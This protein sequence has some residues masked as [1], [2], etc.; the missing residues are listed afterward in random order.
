MNF[1]AL[2]VETA[3]A[4][5]DSICQIGL[6]FFEAGELVRVETRLVD[7]E[8]FF[9][10]FNVSIHGIDED[11]VAGQSNF[12]GHYPWLVNAVAGRIVVTHTAFDVS[13]VRQ[14]C[15]RYGLTVPQVQW[16][17]SARVVRRVW[18]FCAQAGYGLAPLCERFG[19]G[20]KH[21]DAGEDAAA[22][23][24][25]LVRAMGDAGLNEMSLRACLSRP[26]T[27]PLVERLSELSPNPQGEYFGQT[28]VFTGVLAL[29]R[30]DAAKTAADH[31]FLVADGVNKHTDIL[32]VGNQDV[33]KLAGHEKSAKQRKAEQMQIKGKSI[34]I[35]REVDFIDLL[36][37]AAI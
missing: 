26:I 23:G 35:L 32:V 5:F 1:V 15:D 7:P 11:A 27:P 12:A 30:F 25:L 8:D 33:S 22:A 20:F 37:S 31:G 4:G 19:I 34:R 16:I 29:S 18:D 6:A 28:I 17:D 14:S 3:N 24:K 2:D 21:H 9:D 36:R 10:G 13:A